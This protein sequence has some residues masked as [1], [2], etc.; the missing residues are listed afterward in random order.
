MDDDMILA[1]VTARL[2]ALTRD[3][4]RWQVYVDGGR[5]DVVG[6]PDDTR[7]MCALFDLVQSVPGVTG[8]RLFCGQAASSGRLG[9]PEVAQ[10]PAT[11]VH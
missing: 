2:A 1:E 4:R 10:R 11:H 7:M 9:G 6:E 3:S 5:V 8:I